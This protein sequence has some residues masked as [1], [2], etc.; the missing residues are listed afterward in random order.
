MSEPMTPAD[1]RMAVMRHL[2]ELF[3]EILEDDSESRSDAQ[4]EEDKQ[5]ATDLSLE[6]LDAIGLQVVAVDEDGSMTVTLRL[7]D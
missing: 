5:F 3:N 6:V 2:E 1:A 7:E 4:V